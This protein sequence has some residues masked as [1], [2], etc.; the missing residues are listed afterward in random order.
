MK[1]YTTDNKTYE[2]KWI[3]VWAENKNTFTAYTTGGDFIALTL[4]EV[5]KIEE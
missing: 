5:N 3:D 1:I 4:T 2:V